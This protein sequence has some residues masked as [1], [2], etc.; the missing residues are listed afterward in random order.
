[1]KQ[2]RAILWAQWR[3][4]RNFHPWAGEVL[5][6]LVAVV[7]YGLWAAGSAAIAR[8]LAGADL[9]AV[10]IALPIGLGLVLLYWQ[11]VPLLL[12][13]TGAS[14]NLRKLQAYPISTGQLFAV[15]VL[16]R[17][18]AAIEALMV[19][20]GATIGILFNPRL[21]KFGLVAIPLYIFFN[22]VLALG[23]RDLLARL[24]AR[25]GLREIAVFAFVLLITSIQ[26]VAR[27]PQV[28][29]S[30][31]PYVERYSWEGWPWSLAA[32]A[33]ES[34][35]AA[36]LG[37]LGWC[38]I[39]AAFGLWQF[40]RSLTFDAQAASAP[41]RRP[42]T[43]ASFAER[44]YRL[45]SLLLR[46]P[47][48]ALIEK[49]IRFLARSPRFRMVFFMGFT[50]GLVVWLPTAFGRGGGPRS[51]IGAN[52]LTMVSVYS[53]LLLNE[54]CAF[55]VFGFDRSAAQIYFLAPVSFGRVLIGKNLTAAF[56]I[57]LE[58][59]A[60]TTA[61]ALLRM[62]IDA[63]K[64]AE[65]LGVVAVTA[66]FQLAA[67]N[68]LSVRQARGMDPDASLRHSSTARGQAARFI[69][70]P[71]S[72]FPAAFAYLGR[73]AF[74]SE[75]AFFAV[76]AFEAVAGIVVYRIALDSAVAFAEREKESMVAA[77]SVSAGPITA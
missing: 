43:K 40:R 31:Q 52:Y 8:F 66:L 60:V 15:E 74:D 68:L 21:P 72:F 73:Y 48:G 65:A 56:Y 70:L 44:L 22:L 5:S 4:M 36:L 25:R 30:I 24:F 32:R 33:I 46:D 54:V 50:F 51:F 55:N 42:E 35:A 61:C 29:K 16:L 34:R 1:M 59:A 14:L 2:V 10:H 41:Q 62:P 67:G 13:A 53:L 28:F 63:Q 18:T 69:V 27:N 23:I 49:D 77:L 19:L 20:V 12:A 39:A 9:S 26:L 58:I 76:L 71:L 45:P 57:L 7:W 38:A 75:L 11:G 6:I 47:M 3:S 37:L 64:I 17:S